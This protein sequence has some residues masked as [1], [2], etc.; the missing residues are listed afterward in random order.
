MIGWWGIL[1]MTMN[2]WNRY[3][4]IQLYV[5]VLYNYVYASV[6]FTI[7]VDLLFVFKYYPCVDMCH[8]C[9][10]ISGVYKD[11]IGDISAYL[12]ETSV[13]S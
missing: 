1:R 3:R 11:N 9:I 7:H 8:K 4:S 12:E 2:L 10:I 6:M 5:Q 13:I